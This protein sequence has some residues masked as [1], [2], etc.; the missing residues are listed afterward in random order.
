M[1]SVASCDLVH[2]KKGSK[3]FNAP[4]IFFFF[5][6]S[7]AQLGHVSTLRFS[8]CESISA[9]LLPNKYASIVGTAIVW[10]ITGD[11]CTSG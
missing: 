11:L 8:E 9:Q 10:W 7:L 5:T 3:G 2:K 6:F 1:F 4:K